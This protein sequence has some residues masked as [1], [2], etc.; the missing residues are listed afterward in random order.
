MNAVPPEAQPQTEI[1]DI[2]PARKPAALGSP[3]ALGVLIWLSVGLLIGEAAS[4]SFGLTGI[5]LSR[6]GQELLH[7]FALTVGAFVTVYFFV[8]GPLLLEMNIFAWKHSQFRQA[9]EELDCELLKLRSDV[10]DLHKQLHSAHGDRQQAVEDLKCLARQLDEKVVDRTADLESANRRLE[11]ELGALRRSVESSTK[12]SQTAL[13]PDSPPPVQL[14]LAPPPPVASPSAPGSRKADA[15][16]AVIALPC[17]DRSLH[18][19]SAP[20]A[21]ILCD[22]DLRVLSWSQSAARLYGW[23]SDEVLGR[24]PLQVLGSAPVR[25]QEILR[26]IQSNGCWH[27]ELD[28]ISKEG[29]H[30]VV[31]ALLRAT[32]P[33]AGGSGSLLM[34]TADRTATHARYDRALRKHRLDAIRSFVEDLVPDLNSVL[35]PIALGLPLLRSNLGATPDQP[36]FDALEASALQGVDLLREMASLTNGGFAPVRLDPRAL[37]QRVA[38]IGRDIFPSNISL[39]TCTDAQTSD[40]MA[41]PAQLQRALLAICARRCGTM[42][43]G[44]FLE[45]HAANLDFPA[46]TSSLPGD[47]PPGRYVLLRIQDTGPAVSSSDQARSLDPIP[48]IGSDWGLSVALALSIIER[49]GGRLEAGRQRA[50]A[51]SFEICLPA[52]CP[53]SVPPSNSAPPPATPPLILVA[54]EESALREAIR[55]VLLGHGFRVLAVSDGAEALSLLAENPGRVALLLASFNTPSMDAPCLARSAHQ[56]DSQLPILVSS[57]LGPGLGQSR[58]FAALKTL[59]IDRV[60][61]K[62]YSMRELL[63]AIDA[64]ARR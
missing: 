21:I 41:D 25:R 33:T 3:S 23:H 36:F 28:Q 39:L 2:G 49:H 7:L 19:E 1:A 11:S 38:A 40:L 47:P 12:A 45:F 54:E 44:G 64:L 26:S 24:D 46:S 6:G 15:T 52:F 17:P 14:G 32:G 18:L 60:L 53:S 4:W 62:P 63:E 27:G 50:N 37:L 5:A 51:T 48:G 43:S 55:Q 20:D 56:L 58:K 61:P 35:T 29:R 57:A 59:G 34:T 42:P 22:S 9:N 30:L 13:A 8:V 10:A 16:P 31:D